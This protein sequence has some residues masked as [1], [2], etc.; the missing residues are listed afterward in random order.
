MA[1]GRVVR[2]T[3]TGIR[4]EIHARLPQRRSGLALVGGNTVM[5]DEVS[6]V[7]VDEVL[8][9]AMLDDKNTMK[10]VGKG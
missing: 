8:N 1:G 10:G 6:M 3:K 4:L 9:V 5:V 2:E 7:M